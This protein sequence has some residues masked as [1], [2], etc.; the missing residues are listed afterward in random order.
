MSLSRLNAAIGKINDVLCAASVLVWDS[1][2]MLPKGGSAA[3]AEQLATL[4]LLARDLLLSDETR[5][6]LDGARREV[7]T[8][9][10][11]DAWRR[12]VH[13]V[14]E[15][16]AL[17]RRIPATLIERKTKARV[18]GA[19]IWVEARANSDFASF[20]PALADIVAVTRDY[21]DAAGWFGH[22]YD[23]LIGLYEPGATFAEVRTL[24]D[25]LKRG[26]TPILEAALGRPRPARDFLD[27]PFSEEK[28]KAAA[29]LLTEV[30][31]Y[32]YEHGRLDKTVHPFAISF[33]REDVRITMR[34]GERSFANSLFGAM[35][36]TGHGLY[37]QNVDPAFTRTPLTTDL[38]GLHAGGGASLGA[39]ESQSRL[40]ENHVGR[41]R[42]F[43]H[44]HFGRMKEVL[45][46]LDG[47]EAEAFQ[48]AVNDVS[49]GLI[50]TEADELTYDFH[51]MLRVELEAALLTGDIKVAEIP[52]AWG[53]A[54]KRHLGVA[55]PNDREG[56]LQDVHWASGSIGSFCTY[57]LG[58]VMAAQLF[59]AANRRGEGVA[60]GLTKGDTAPL[61]LWLK[62]N[63][64]RHGKRFTRDELL[65]R[66]TGRALEAG[67]YLRYLEG[68]YGKA[69]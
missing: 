68:K 47:V 39:H 28:V 15:A 59:E 44:A 37:E 58:N 64:W 16:I 19:Q 13:K 46:G 24:L 65:T 29:R 38:V 11:D 21:A 17:H 18:L 55:V 2:T 48:L 56:C 41:S 10:Q 8:L 1:R 36:E 63:V 53:E 43:W 3:R 62:E 45:G 4:S 25:E 42:D 23:V 61:R 27:E 35:H 20:A 5:K 49:P 31:G 26:I 6:A 30:L 7:E 57:T 60:Q 52:G 69:A 54:M 66:A 14:D 51:I 34:L 67:P 50:R 32:D 9:P 33:T 22:P 40:Q 12:A